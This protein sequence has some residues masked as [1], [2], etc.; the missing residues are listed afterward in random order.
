MSYETF[1]LGAAAST[2]TS[3]LFA[4]RTEAPKP[5]QQTSALTTVVETLKSVVLPTATKE[6]CLAPNVKNVAPAANRATMLARGCK[7]TGVSGAYDIWCCPKPATVAATTQ[8]PPGYQPPTYTKPAIPMLKTQPPPPSVA[9]KP[10]VEDPCPGGKVIG[11]KD[12]KPIC[13]YEDLVEKLTADGNVVIEPDGT[14]VDQDIDNG[15]LVVEDEVTSA[16][17]PRGLS[18]KYILI[19][20][21]IG[22]GVWFL[23]KKFA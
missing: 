1:G 8:P 11:V 21:G 10:T 16:V 5:A 9:V 13:A 17:A 6:P 15:T 19:G 23:V 14:V 4:T 3:W 2:D 20:A 7:R 18:I 22:V 12:G